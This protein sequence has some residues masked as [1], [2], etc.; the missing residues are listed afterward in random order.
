MLRIMEVN[1]KIFQSDEQVRD[2]YKTL[3]RIN[4]EPYM[5]HEAKAQAVRFIGLIQ[6]TNYDAVK[7]LTVPGDNI[8]FMVGPCITA[9]CPQH[10][11]SEYQEPYKRISK[12][13]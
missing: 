6:A 3:I 5:P 13:C 4:L 8:S 9:D 2:F 10:L 11:R 7:D 1:M 12:I